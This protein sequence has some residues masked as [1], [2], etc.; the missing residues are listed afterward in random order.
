MNLRCVCK[1]AKKQSIDA[2]QMRKWIR[3]Y[4]PSTVVG[5]PRGLVVTAAVRVRRR[6]VVAVAGGG[7]G[8]T[9]GRARAGR[10]DAGP[11]S[12]G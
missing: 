10:V 9:E 6:V 1:N 3:N 2:I 8:R 4:L 5:H 7:P 11:G 12:G